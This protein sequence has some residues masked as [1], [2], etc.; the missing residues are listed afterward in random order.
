M[1][2]FVSQDIVKL[3]L[4]EGDFVNVRKELAYS[5]I[6]LL[7]GSAK[8]AQGNEEESIKLGI[9]LL[10]AAIV[11]WEMKGEDG[12][13]VEYSPEKIE[14]LSIQTITELIEKLAPMY[15]PEKKSS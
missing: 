12:Q 10:R 14:Q 11:S 9:P 5:Q 1:S 13:P 3:D 2:R 8:R 6:E 7:L 15:F 4:G